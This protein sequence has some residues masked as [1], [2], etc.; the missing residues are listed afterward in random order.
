MK[1]ALPFVALIAIGATWGAGQPLARIAVSDGYR[2]LGILVWQQ[3]VIAAMLG[4]TTLLRGRRL[5]WDRGALGLYLVIALIGSVLPGLAS[6]SAAVHLPAGV[7]SILLSAVPMLAFPLALAL[8]IDSFRWRRFAGLALG[9]AGVLLLVLPREGLPPGVPAPW[10]GVA[11]LASACYAVEGNYVQKRGTRGLDPVQVLTG[12]SILGTAL[13]LPLAVAS[14][15]WIDPRGP[16]AAPDTAILASSVSHG[17]AYA[18]YVWLVGA[19]GSVFAVQVSYLV[20]LFG[21][22]WAMLFLGEGYSGWV[23]AALALMV[24]GLALVQ[25]RPRGLVPTA[26]L[27]QDAAG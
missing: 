4:A 23:W 22:S 1:R 3:C 25:P 12:A 11:L 14:G 7:L 9:L 24:A 6:Y 20:T 8:G 19:A 27:G 16:W 21:V 10:V 2:P 18:G 5:P 13:T 15:Q 17:V 26:P